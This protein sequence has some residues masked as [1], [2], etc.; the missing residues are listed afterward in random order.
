MGRFNR[1]A[2]I[3]A[4][5]ALTSVSGVLSAN[6]SLVDLGP[7]SSGGQGTGATN[8]NLITLLNPGN[9]T[10][11]GFTS[12][13]N[14]SFSFDGD[15]QT[16]LDD[17]S[18]HSAPALSDLGW[19]N[20]SD[21]KVLFNGNEGNGPNAGVTINTITLSFFTASGGLVGTITNDLGAL[22]Y[23][24]AQAGQGSAGFLI[25]VAPSDTVE[26]TLLQGLLNQAG[27][28]GHV[29]IFASLSNVDGGAETFTAVGVA[30]VPEP[31]TWAMMILGFAGVGFLA[32]RRRSKGAA[33]GVS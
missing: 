27:P 29:G 2:A 26:L 22:V 25:G 16:P 30:A 1:I 19:T 18:K 8:F 7:V 4:L 3:A 17:K 32:Y 12:Y 11:A 6:A 9:S 10:A 13:L 14:G 24:T 15:L 28:T 20:A 23:P 33:F 31:S 21:V 5:A